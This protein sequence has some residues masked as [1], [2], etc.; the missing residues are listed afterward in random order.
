M[1]NIENLRE[2]AILHDKLE[3]LGAAQE[4]L[5]EM[6]DENNWSEDSLRFRDED[7][8]I[9][10]NLTGVVSRHDLINSIGVILSSR[11]AELNNRAEE[12]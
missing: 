11:K 3:M 7:S 10:L 2:A 8:H 6:L 12:L 5:S 1:M 9:E 4:R